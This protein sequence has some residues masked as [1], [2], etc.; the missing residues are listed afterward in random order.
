MS[1]ERVKRIE[2]WKNTAGV[3]LSNGG[4]I[5][6]EVGGGGRCFWVPAHD[7]TGLNGTRVTS[8]SDSNQPNNATDTFRG[9]PSL[10]REHM[11]VLD[12]ETLG[13]G[14]SYD[15]LFVEWHGEG[16]A[17]SS[18]FA[19]DAAAPST[20]ARTWWSS[21]GHAWAAGSFVG[22]K[23]PPVVCYNTAE[24]GRNSSPMSG[25]TGATAVEPQI[26]AGGFS[27]M[28]KSWGDP[29]IAG[30]ADVRML[31]AS[32]TKQVLPFG[33]NAGQSL[34]KSGLLWGYSAKSSGADISRYPVGGD[35]YGWIY[36]I[37]YPAGGGSYYQGGITPTGQGVYP[38]LNITGLSRVWLAFWETAP[39]TGATSP[40]LNF[41]SASMSVKGTITAILINDR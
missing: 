3:T 37:G 1:V 19:L 8:E 22:G 29:S 17:N 31:Y 10:R 23:E 7:W 13:G 25:A 35:Q 15:R 40:Y 27:L 34:S 32:S 21:D 36:E 38:D 26:A 33:L 16:A 11:F 9:G 6:L 39:A 5:F 24:A 4:N 28:V 41:T 14:V 2:I 12:L 18:G 30:A 20:L